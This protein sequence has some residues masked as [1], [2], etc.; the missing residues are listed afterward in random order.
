VKGV[1]LAMGRAIARR[2]LV[3]R[4]YECPCCGYESRERVGLLETSALAKG[5]GRLAC[6]AR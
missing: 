4:V 2:F 6:G 1:W 3:Q 5:G